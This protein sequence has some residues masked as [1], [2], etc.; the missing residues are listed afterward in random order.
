MKKSKKKPAKGL[1]KTIRRKVV[2]APAA[3][4][5][6]LQKEDEV[7]LLETD[8]VVLLEMT[9]PNEFRDLLKNGKMQFIANVKKLAAAANLESEVRVY[10]T[11][12]TKK[13]GVTTN[14]TV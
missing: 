5:F 12:K 2:I 4:S 8:P 6:P 10:F 1:K 13:K 7:Q 9:K 14:G 3:A 11:F